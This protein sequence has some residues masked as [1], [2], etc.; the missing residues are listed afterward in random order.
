MLAIAERSRRHTKHFSLHISVDIEIEIE[1]GTRSRKTLPHHHAVLCS[2]WL[3]K[4]EVKGRKNRCKY[5]AKARRKVH[6]HITTDIV[7]MLP[8]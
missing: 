4:C 6:K 1:I 8:C 5:L 3:L 2:A 7:R